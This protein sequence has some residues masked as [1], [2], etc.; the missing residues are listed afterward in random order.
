MRFETNTKIPQNAFSGSW[1]SPPLSQLRHPGQGLCHFPRT[2]NLNYMLTCP[3]GERE[4]S[5]RGCMSRT[6]TARRRR[7]GG[8]EEGERGGGGKP[9]GGKTESSSFATFPTT[10]KA[11]TKPTTIQSL[12]PG[13][14]FSPYIT[15]TSF[16]IS[17]TLFPP[18]SSSVELQH[19]A[20]GGWQGPHLLPPLPPGASSPHGAH[21]LLERPPSPSAN[22]QLPRVF[23]RAL[24]TLGHPLADQGTSPMQ[25]NPLSQRISFPGS[26]RIQSP[27]TCASFWQSASSQESPERAP[28]LLILHLRMFSPRFWKCRCEDSRCLLSLFLYYLS[29]SLFT[30]GLIPVSP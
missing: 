2:F 28:V 14:P 19:P 30:P 6:W 4:H 13:R 7:W 25:E 12:K 22:C 10:F 29:L 1:G 17:F 26:P 23:C 11:I 3:P 21:L 18:G 20:A 8:G 27:T 16:S 24:Q 5:K 15:I 9:G